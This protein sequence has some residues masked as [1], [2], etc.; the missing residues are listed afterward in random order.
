MLTHK[1]A[2]PQNELNMLFHV[3]CLKMNHVFACLFFAS[4][5][6][7]C[8]LFSYDS[9]VYCFAETAAFQVIAVEEATDRPGRCAHPF[10]QIP[11]VRTGNR[12]PTEQT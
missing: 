9:Q 12:K 1:T 8:A 5:S 2:H 3:K 7:P 10:A 6:S 11:R 4:A